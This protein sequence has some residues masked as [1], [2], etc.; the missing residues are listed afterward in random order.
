[1]KATP[2]KAV[3]R[4]PFQDARPSE[5]LSKQIPGLAV[6]EMPYTVGGSDQAGDL[7]GLFDASIG[8]LLGAQQ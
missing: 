1:L 6:I 3:I 8:L 5:W 7:F 4:A 2:A